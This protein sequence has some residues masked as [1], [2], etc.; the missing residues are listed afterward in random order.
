MGTKTISIIMPMYNAAQF[1]PSAIDCIRKQTWTDWELVAV[2]DGS[3][4]NTKEL[5]QKLTADI[6]QPVRYQ[7]RENGGGF[8]ARNT[9]L[10]AATGPFLAFYDCDD[11][12][13]PF[14][15]ER[16]MAA[17]EANPEV[18]W[19]FASNRVVDIT[20][21][22]VLNEDIFYEPDGTPRK[23]LSLRHR[24]SGNLSI[25]EDP[26]AAR[27][28]ILHGINCGQQF[29]VIRSNVF[30]GYRF[31]ADYRN[32]GADQVSV[33]R[34]LSNG[35]TFGYLKECHGIYAVH[36]SNASAGCKGAPLEKYLRLRRALIR[37]FEELRTEE[38]LNQDEQRAIDRRIANEY[39]W[40]IGYNLFWARGERWQAVQQ[41][42]KGIGYW[43]WD[44][45][46]WKT[47]LTATGR[48]L[49]FPHGKEVATPK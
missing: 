37:G 38:P 29:S 7:W 16:C 41:F 6:T 35:F 19:V 5:F 46:M 14:H 25:I 44:L 32:E 48:A 18:D 43:P 36:G 11:Q 28:Q 3:S 1:L 47:F 42:A 12:W 34:S 8:A 9:G 20:D 33:I 13:Y 27:C 17:L 30:Q 21:N 24:N 15:L 39:F 22:S 2:D 31:R 49:F 23:M 45:R 26:A 10:D 4:D 40:D